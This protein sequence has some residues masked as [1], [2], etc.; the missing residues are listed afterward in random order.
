MKGQFST[1]FCKHMLF[2]TWAVMCNSKIIILL[3]LGG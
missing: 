2:T 1:G 3:L